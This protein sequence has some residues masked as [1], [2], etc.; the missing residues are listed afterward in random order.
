MLSP[1]AHGSWAVPAWHV[2]TKLSWRF[3]RFYFGI[4]QPIHAWRLEFHFLYHRLG[5]ENFLDVQCT[6]FPATE[7]ALRGYYFVVGAGFA[8]RVGVNLSRRFRPLLRPSHR[9]WPAR[10]C[11]YFDCSWYR[12]LKET[13]MQAYCL[14][15]TFFRRAAGPP[16]LDLTRTCLRLPPSGQCREFKG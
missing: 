14:A 5:G 10:P 15:R 12:K 7:K 13:K 1:G 8:G 3:C 4:S 6:Q 2:T 16:C 11:Q 9:P